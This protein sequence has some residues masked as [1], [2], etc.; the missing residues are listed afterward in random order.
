MPLASPRSYNAIAQDI[1]EM[2]VARAAAGQAFAEL[3]QQRPIEPQR[4]LLHH[5]TRV[6]HQHNNSMS[7]AAWLLSAHESK[8]HSHTQHQAASGRKGDIA[9]AET[10][11]HL[12]L[13]E[14]AVRAQ[15]RYVLQIVIFCCLLQAA[16]H[17]A[18]VGPK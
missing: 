10:I 4:D 12:H 15:R 6:N 14:A 16:E 5:A 18:G 3:R 11:S 1:E 9:S 2:E 17:A 8:Q 7:G 13:F